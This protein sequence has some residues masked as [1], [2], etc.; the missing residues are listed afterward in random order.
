MEIEPFPAR[1]GCAQPVSR[2]KRGEES[3]EEHQQEQADE[4]G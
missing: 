1:R 2:I 3:E 4:D